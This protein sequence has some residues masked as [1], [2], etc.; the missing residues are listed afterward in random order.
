MNKFLTKFVE[1]EGQVSEAIETFDV[2]WFQGMDSALIYTH[3]C[4][5]AL[6]IFIGQNGKITPAH[7]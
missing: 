4:M 7:G 3:G 2:V 5:D 1:I 6:T